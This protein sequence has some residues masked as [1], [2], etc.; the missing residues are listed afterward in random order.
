MD[1]MKTNAGPAMVGGKRG[2]ALASVAAPSACNS[3][4]CSRS[5]NS[6]GA[7]TYQA[8]LAQRPSANTAAGGCASSALRRAGHAARTAA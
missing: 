5:A 4:Q 1:W 2:A 7:S 3:L 8:V 6:P